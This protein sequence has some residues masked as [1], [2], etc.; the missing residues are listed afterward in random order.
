[1]LTIFCCSC[2]EKPIATEL[3]YTAETIHYSESAAF[4][5]F[6]KNME[7]GESERAVYYFE[8]TADADLR[9]VCI[10]ATERILKEFGQLEN[11]PNIV[12]FSTSSNQGVRIEGNTLYIT[13]T[14]W[15]SIGYVCDVLLTVGGA[16]SHYGLA[17]GY[18]NILCERFEWDE[19]TDGVFT[20][21]KEMSV[22]DLSLLCFETEFVSVEDCFAAKQTACDFVSRYIDE[23]G[24]DELQKLLIA[25]ASSEGMEKLS[26]ALSGY[27]AQNG[28]S[29]VPSILRFMYGGSSFQYVVGGELGKFYV[30]NDWVDTLYENDPLIHENFLH[31]NY[32]EVKEFFEVSLQQMKDYQELFALNDYDNTLE[33]VFLKSPTLRTSS[34]NENTHRIYVVNITSM[35]HEYIHSITAVE[36]TTELW[37][38][39]GFARYFSYWYDVY[40]L[41]YLNWYYNNEESAEYVL[42][43]RNAVGRNIN[44]A[45][46]FE[47]L[48]NLLVYVNGWEDPNLN[49]ATGSSFVQYLVHQ[50][51]VERVVQ[52]I[53][54]DREPLPKSYDELVAGWVRFVRENCKEYI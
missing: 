8:S 14:D 6:S 28:V 1:M 27:Y 23:R 37:E 3:T 34:Y 17:Y 44:I 18:A 46:D 31:E 54:G 39:E 45:E 43:Y 12:V 42:N 51:G 15:N 40:G 2:T 29:Y 13:P 33:V 35:M 24:E 7:C 11:K 47:A 38:S 32:K 19:P 20:M 50:Y 49:Y 10:E 9:T 53:Y 30:G 4:Y 48:E 21:P 25:S 26:G 5:D 22:L 16:G 36:K 52:H 41:P